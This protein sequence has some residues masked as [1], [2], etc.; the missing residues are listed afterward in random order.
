MKFTSTP[1]PDPAFGTTYRLQASGGAGKGIVFS[2]APATTNRA[3]SLDGAGTTVTFDHAG[4]CVIAAHATTR[5]AA[6]RLA[7]RGAADDVTQTVQV[8]KGR[9]HLDFQLRAGV[10]VGDTLP[11]SATRGAS[12]RP[13]TFTL[14]TPD[15]CALNGAGTAVSFQHAGPCTVTAHEDGDADYH[16][17]PD[18]S[19]TVD[20]AK[21]D[22]TLEF[23]PVTAA[24]VGSG[25]TLHATSSAGLD[26]T[27]ATTDAACTV[28]GST[29]T[30]VHA[31]VCDITASAGNSDYNDATANQTITIARGDQQ[32]AFTL[33]SDQPVVR[34]A[35]TL[36]VTAQGDSGNPVTFSSTTPDVCTVTGTTVTFQHAQACSVEATQPASDDYNAADAVTHTL[37]VGKADQQV[38]FTL[39]SDQPVVRGA[40]TLAVTAQGDSGNPVTF[41]STTPDVCT[42]TGTTVTFQHAQAC[43]VEATQP[44]SD[45]YNAADAVTH[46]LQVGKAD[47]QVA[48]TLTSDLPVVRGVGT[49][50]VTAHGD[51]GNPVTF[52][53]TTPDVCTFN[54]TSVTLDHAGTCTI[55]ADQ[56]GDDDYL[57][58][59]TVTRTVTIRKA[60]QA[61]GFTL[62][63]APALGSSHDLVATGGGSGNAVTFTSTTP[64][65]CSVTGSTVTFDH[66]GT[67]VIAADQAGNGDYEA[68]PTVT[69]SV[70]VAKATQSITFTS[71]A[72]A[73]ATLGDTYAVTAASGSG[74]PVTFSVDPA[75]TNAACTVAGATV[76]FRHAGTCVIAADQ[77]GNA[78]YLAAPTVTQAVT[79]H[80]ASQSIT[81]T[82]KAPSPGFV[83]TT[84]SVAA[85]GGD[86]GNP[87]V[88]R[89]ATLKVCTV[90]GSTVTFG[91]AG[92][93]NISAD[94]A[95]TPDYDAAPTVTQNVNVVVRDA[96]LAVTAAKGADIGGL[97]GVTAS[98]T[99]LPADATATLTASASGSNAFRPEGVAA[100]ACTRQTATRYTCTVKA[101]QTDFTFAVNTENSR[102]VTFAVEPD[103]PLIDSHR[104]NNTFVVHWHA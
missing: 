82:S 23:T 37:L 92:T 33:A 91:G 63:T 45:D 26:V 70:G 7:A 61:I 17:A 47:Q 43:S 12:G 80:K 85:S 103:P 79:V 78:D 10:R 62:P 2:I 1:P 65:K 29:V 25:A 75:T 38:A 32:V 22:Q 49:L 76:A 86:S 88:F 84:Y 97:S 19:L 16:A 68:A 48:F 94:Q 90:S 55:A 100:N 20:V 34:G 6:R 8:P 54:G 11:L 60:T 15:V 31:Q 99:G 87:V 72:P 58:A 36:A 52:I 67:C 30:F 57:A 13:V 28:S 27:F 81:I 95:G 18:R 5:S 98:V 66:A 51:S 69:R 102:D 101:G 50:A 104:G 40:G 56:A 9:Q 46:T 59:P 41:S 24:K 64:D 3:C 93:C 89:S 14:D 96:D 44:A 4:T 73:S 21:G 39:T 53:S 42:V 71:K 74:A 83:G 77:A 35:G